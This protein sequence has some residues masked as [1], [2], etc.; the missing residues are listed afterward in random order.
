VPQTQNKQKAHAKKREVSD[1]TCSDKK[2]AEKQGGLGA[3]QQ[4]EEEHTGK[5]RNRT[6]I[7]WRKHMY[8][9]N[10]IG[11]L[12]KIGA[13]QTN[14]PWG[15]HTCSYTAAYTCTRFTQNPSMPRL[16]QISQNS[17]TQHEEQK[18]RENMSSKR[19]GEITKEG[20]AAK[21]APVLGSALVLNRR[22]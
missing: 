21:L 14:T 1:Q 10:L 16:P 20:A 6:W 11:V 5:R 18:Y 3:H 17:L 12:Q 4:E 7:S 19:K 9:A 15:K 22:Y 13:S 8:S 2:K